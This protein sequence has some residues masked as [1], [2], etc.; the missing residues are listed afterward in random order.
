V[1]Q[2]TVVPI[3]QDVPEIGGVVGGFVVI[4]PEYIHVV[5]EMPRTALT[6]AV[7]AALNLPLPLR[8]G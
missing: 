4:Y 8:A 3:T 2:P 6:P 7:L 5:T 1:Q